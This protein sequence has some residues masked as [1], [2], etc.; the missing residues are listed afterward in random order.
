MAIKGSIKIAPRKEPRISVNKLAE[1][2]QAS[3]VRRKQIVKDAKYPPSYQTTR[4]KDA[5][6]TMKNYLLNGDE[7]PVLELIDKL[8]LIEEF[9]SD[10]QEQDNRLSIEALESLLTADISVFEG[11]ELRHYG[12]DNPYVNIKGV[13]ISVN[14]DMLIYYSLEGTSY[15]GA[16]KLHVSKSNILSIE[17][18][19]IV[20]VMLYNFVDA[21]EARADIIP[22]SRVCFS[23]DVFN[24]TIESCPSSRK[25]R[26]KNIEVACEEIALWWDKI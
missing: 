3:T 15:V 9:D 17:S 14:P 13:D 2:L 23:F 24:K 6:N 20:A 26:L 7:D 18:Q 4:Y 1:Y 16:L 19:K 22:D 21:H 10:F 25:L 8:D 11:Y 5:R 12:G